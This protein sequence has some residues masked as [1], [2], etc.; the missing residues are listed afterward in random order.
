IRTNTKVNTARNMINILSNK[1]YVKPIIRHLIN[2]TSIDYIILYDLDKL[3]DNCAHKA[4]TNAIRST[5]GSD[6]I[7]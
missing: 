2:Q 3:G 6:R 5:K 1:K 7:L 4:S